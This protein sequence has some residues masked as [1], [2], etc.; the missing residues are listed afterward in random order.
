MQV[1][2]TVVIPGTE[3]IRGTITFPCTQPGIKEAGRYAW[4]SMRGA[5]KDRAL[6]AQNAIRAF[7]EGGPNIAIVR[8]QHRRVS[9]IELRFESDRPIE[10]VP[11][12]RELT[13]EEVDTVAREVFHHGRRPKIGVPIRTHIR[14]NGVYTEVLVSVKGSPETHTVRFFS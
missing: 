3:R 7:I 8:G 1:T 13:P 9:P 2:M 11:Q 10:Q 6:M 5:T 4:A 12:P 14:E